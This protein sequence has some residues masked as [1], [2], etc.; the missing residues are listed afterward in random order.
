METIR[1]QRKRDRVADALGDTPETAIPTHLLRRG[2]ADAYIAGSLP[3]FDGAI[4]QSHSLPY[5]PWCFGTDPDVQWQLLCRLN[6]WGRRRVSPNVSADLAGPLSALM[7]RTAKVEVRHYG[8]VYHT[9]TGR[10]NE[11]ATPEVRLLGVGDSDL[12][13][14]FESDPRR[15]GFKTFEDLLKNGIRGRG[16]G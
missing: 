4:V 2:L 7:K 8:D 3:R 5:E 11:F 12:L 9:L 16:R 15:L 13:A 1:K 6:G 10:V 14:A